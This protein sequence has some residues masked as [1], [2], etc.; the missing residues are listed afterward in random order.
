MNQRGGWRWTYG[1]LGWGLRKLDVPL[2]PII[3]G[4]LL[5]NQME[6]NLRRA[7]TISD[8]MNRFLDLTMALM[9]AQAGEEM[10]ECD[11]QI[12]PALEIARPLRLGH[13]DHI[14]RDRNE[15]CRYKLKRML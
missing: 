1:V 15:P 3:L 7:M 9:L 11:Q 5:G 2:V 4:V 12:I 8:G 14:L 13:C 10:G 6:A